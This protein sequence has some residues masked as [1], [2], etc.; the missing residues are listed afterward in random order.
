MFGIEAKGV[1]Y[2]LGLSLTLSGVNL[3]PIKVAA[4]RRTSMYRR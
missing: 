2:Y 3:L 1:I 4:G